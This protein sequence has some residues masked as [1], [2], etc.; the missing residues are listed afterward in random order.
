MIKVVMVDL[1]GTLLTP[2]KKIT[3]K[4]VETIKRFQEKGGLFVVNTGR[5]YS[6]ASKIVK[7]A[8]IKCDYICLSGAGIY[9]DLGKCIKC[10]YM[11]EEEIS[12]VQEI[13]KKYGL[14]INYLT[15][16]GE[17]SECSKE[18]AE[19]YYLQEEITA[20]EKLGKT[21]D[22]EKVLEK[23]RGI[24]NHI[25]YSSDICEIM[26]PENHIFKMVVMSMD[27]NSIAKAKEELAKHLKF[28]VAMTSMTSMEVNSIRA[29]KGNAAI[30]YIKSKGMQMDEVMAIG[31]S[32]NDYAMLE[33]P[34]GKTV[35]MEN[36]EPEIKEICTDITKSNLEDGVAFAIEKMVL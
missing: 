31:D 16:N 32:E 6:T 26:N 20:A 19:Q 5:S 25:K 30:D 4:T 18:W 10:D 14:K 35:A 27:A 1:D 9:D 15:S 36:A 7:E 2:E 17:F 13:E 12:I 33:L 23:Y 34:F 28:K 22:T 24:L 29:D 11:T 3:E 21:I 8:G